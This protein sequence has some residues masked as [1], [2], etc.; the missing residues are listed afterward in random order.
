[1]S[2]TQDLPK[3]DSADLSR[4][5]GGM[6]GGGMQ[7]LSGLLGGLKGAGQQGQPGEDGAAQAA[8]PSSATGG[9]GGFPM[10]QLMAFGSNPS[11]QTGMS[12]IQ[13]LMAKSGQSQQ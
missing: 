5:T 8:Q 1:M 3:L 4:V 13:A 2:A 10:D 12:L 6:Q 7:L 11:L 9:A